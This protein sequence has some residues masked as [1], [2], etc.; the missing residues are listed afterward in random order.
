[1]RAAGG[2]ADVDDGHQFGMPN[3]SPDLG[4]SRESGCLATGDLPD[5]DLQGE[6]LTRSVTR[7]T[8]YTAPIPPAPSSRRTR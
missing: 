2:D 4:L 7:S 5:D 3:P 6:A 8:S 1:M